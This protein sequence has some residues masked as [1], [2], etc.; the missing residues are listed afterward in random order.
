MTVHTSDSTGLLAFQYKT[1]NGQPL[2]QE[3]Q[4]PVE[5]L[6]HAKHHRTPCQVLFVVE[7]KFFG[8]C[9]TTSDYM[10]E[11]ERRRHGGAS[12]SQRN[13]CIFDKPVTEYCCYC[14]RD[15]NVSIFIHQIRFPLIWF[16]SSSSVLFFFCSSSS[17]A[18]KVTQCAQHLCLPLEPL[19]MVSSEL[20]WELVS[21]EHIQFGVKAKN[22]K[23]ST[24]NSDRK[25]NWHTLL[26]R[27]S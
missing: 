26:H 18:V 20:S 16:I 14:Y 2:S 10:Y 25:H 12:V 4:W 6:H 11:A 15:V 27:T 21:S 9:L 8:C 22:K 7:V 23:N 13:W 24:E 5:S 1:R 17:S 3:A 19:I